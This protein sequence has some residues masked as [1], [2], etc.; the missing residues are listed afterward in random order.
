M[1]Y[2]IFALLLPYVPSIGN[3]FSGD[4]WF[5]LQITQIHSFSEFLNFFSFTHTAQS[6]AFYRPLPT[7]VFFFIFQQFFGLTSWPYHV[8]V[9]VCFAYSLYLVYLFAKTRLKSERSSL[10]AM[11]IYG[12]S[13]SN[14][15]RLYFLSAFQEIALVI[16]TLLCLLSFPKSKSRTIIFFVLALLSK[17]TAV[18]IPFLLVLFHY[19]TIKKYIYFYSLI[20]A[21]L[22][23]YVFFRFSVFGGPAG[24]T[25]LWNFSPFKAVNTLFWYVLWSLGAPEFLVDYVGS[26]LKLIPRF[27]TD[28]YF[29]WKIIIPTLIT[30]IISLCILVFRK[31]KQVNLSVLQYLLFFFITLLPVLFLP[32]H[33][34]AL[35]LGLPLVGFSLVISWLTSARADKFAIV[36]LSLYVFLN[37]SSN[38]ITFPRHYSVGR[39]EVSR[40]VFY[41]FSSLHPV[42]PAG[43]YFEFIND[44]SGYFGKEWGQSKQVSQSL[45]GSDFFKVF[46]KNPN[47]KVYY[48]DI[49]EKGF[50]PDKNSL[51][52]LGTQQFL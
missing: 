28:F 17:E 29:W 8:F 48:Q 22:L 3:F 45:S 32:S 9:L 46:Y 24:D 33:K 23:V 44:S 37:L 30:T 39:G 15:T 19:K 26:G 38:L 16:F 35:E 5:H 42:Y 25:Y 18:V 31:Y 2:L 6:A 49:P 7:Q 21:I 12:L 13:V 10:I 47:I 4:D 1:I 36:F 14:F 43:K 40:N 41:Y 34:F 52:Y 50:T 51:I 20:T 11:G 27:F